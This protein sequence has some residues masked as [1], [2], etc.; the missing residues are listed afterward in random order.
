[1][2]GGQGFTGR[3][4]ADALVAAGHEPSAFAADVTDRAAVEAAVDAARPDAVIHLAA[5][6]FVHSDDV[7]GFYAINQIGTFHLLDALARTAPGVPVLLAS[8]ATIYGNAASG[9]LT[10]DAPCAPANHYAASKLAMEIG[11]RLW[12]DRFPI[13]TVRPFNYTG[14]GQDE[15]YLIAKIVAHFRRRDAVIELGNLDVARDFGDV[16]AV[17]Q[18]Y[19]GLIEQRTG[20]VYNVCTGAVHSIR[21][22]IA[23]CQAITGHAIEVRVNPAFVRANDVALLAGNPARLRAALPQWQVPTMHDTL[24]WML[25]PA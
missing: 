15:R 24:A 11:A 14:R 22:I 2:T 18:A 3:Y 12:A 17:V 19:V 23:M 6:A 21:D 7:V 25:E 4:L 5:S 10:E 1:M 16:R 13:V 9:Y 8:S 20:G